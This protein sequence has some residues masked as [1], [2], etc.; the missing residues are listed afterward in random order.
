[1]HDPKPKSSIFLKTASTTGSTPSVRILPSTCL[2]SSGY[3]RTF[4]IHPAFPKS[5]SIRS[6]PMEMSEACEAIS[7]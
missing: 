7:T 6:V 5:I 3:C 4:S 2:T 1:M